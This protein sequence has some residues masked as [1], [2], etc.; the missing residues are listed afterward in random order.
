MLA[1]LAW[2]AFSRARAKTGKSVAARMAMIAITTSTDAGVCSVIPH[3]VLELLLAEDSFAG[4]RAPG[5]AQASAERRYRSLS[6]TTSPVSAL[7]RAASMIAINWRV[8]LR[9]IATGSPSVR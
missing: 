9:G 5:E 8:S 4:G 7:R 3:V 6:G 1:Q 2:R